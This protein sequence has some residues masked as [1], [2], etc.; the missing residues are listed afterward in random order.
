MAKKY[1]KG[2][3]VKYGDFFVTL[4]DGRF[5]LCADAETPATDCKARPVWLI[6]FQ[7]GIERLVLEDDL[8]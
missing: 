7:D 3:T 2:D 8:C 4:K 1:K 5:M 6:E